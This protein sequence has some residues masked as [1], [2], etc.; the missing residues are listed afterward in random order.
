MFP[1]DATKLQ[2]ANSYVSSTIAIGFKDT[3]LSISS[4]KPAEYIKDKA[5]RT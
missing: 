4:Q 2:Q 1:S 3:P 5:T